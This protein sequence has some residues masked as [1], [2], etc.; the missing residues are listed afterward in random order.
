MDET[1]YYHHLILLRFISVLVKMILIL[2]QKL[3]LGGI[4]EEGFVV[5]ELSFFSSLF[6]IWIKI[7]LKTN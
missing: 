6:F 2:F 3:P 7:S 4:P 5:F 1:K